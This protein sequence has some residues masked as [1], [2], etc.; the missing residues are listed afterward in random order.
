VNYVWH[1]TS[2]QAGNTKPG[3]RLD[4]NAFIG[5]WKR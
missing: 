1:Y 3:V 4:K 2:D 5:S